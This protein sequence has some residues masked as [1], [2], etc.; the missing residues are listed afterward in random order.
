[1]Y[2]LFCKC[3]ATEIGNI[4]VI[5]LTSI[6]QNCPHKGINHP[7]DSM[8]KTAQNNVV[9]APMVSAMCHLDYLMSN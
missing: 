6:L 8:R 7:V 1:M 2:I 3:I 5:N 9:V 4:I